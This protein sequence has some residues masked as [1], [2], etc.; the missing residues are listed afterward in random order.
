MKNKTPKSVYILITTAATIIL[1]IVFEVTRIFLIKPDVD[2]SEELLK[3]I[4]PLID[5]QTLDNIN[6]R[7]FFEPGDIPKLIV[8]PE[9]TN[10]A[11]EKI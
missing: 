6:S 5:A 8:A 9:A 10:S 4:S 1:W 3:P 7:T 11:N 2:V